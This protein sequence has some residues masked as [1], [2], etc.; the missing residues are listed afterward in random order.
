MA[1]RFEFLPADVLGLS[2]LARAGLSGRLAELGWARS[3]DELEPPAV[4]RDPLAL[5]ERQV[6][7]ARLE[8]SVASLEPPV[9]VLDAVRLLRRP[10]AS[11]V[12]ARRPAGLLASPLATLHAAAAAVRLARSLAQRWERPVVAG[13]W[14]DDTASAAP[15]AWVLGRHH[16]L[17]R[18]SLEALGDAPWPTRVELGT[19][20]RVG[21]LRAAARH[22]FGDYP[23]VDAALELVAPREGETLA[24]AT[25]RML[26]GAFGAH[27][28]VPIDP[29]ALRAE[30]ASSLARLA[31]TDV[32][33]AFERTARELGG[34]AA[35]GEEFGR[36]VV[37]LRVGALAERLRVGGEGYVSD[38]LAGARTR[39]ELAAAAVQEPEHWSPGPALLPACLEAALPVAVH[40]AGGGDDLPASLARRALLAPLGLEAR[41]LVARAPVTLVEPEVRADLDRA[42]VSA[43]AALREGRAE[44]TPPLQPTNGPS[45][46]HAVAEALRRA[47]AKAREKVLEPKAELA[48]I[49][50]GLAS[51]LER[52]G[53]DIG[54]GLEKLARRVEHAEA[55]LR[56]QDRR[57]ARRIAASL[58]PNGGAQEDTLSSFQYLARHGT[59]WLDAL[60]DELE[61]FGAEHVV[62]T[63]KVPQ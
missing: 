35:V 19:A 13:L 49:D 14:I 26:T 31:A 55:N 22:L 25:A 21:A 46:D 24:R 44:S 11:L 5:E 47:A 60:V 62:L 29:S 28:L 51:Q 16:D 23:H 30:L 57:R 33:G 45:S 56:G 20:H 37:A 42:G 15:E 38:G 40:V 50:P 27:G 8:L 6:L 9:A 58:T 12:L 43:E 52:I 4:E 54:G 2:A 36:G 61:P 34:V 3:M 59:G 18:L 32:G 48:R 7:V 17:Q 53:R 10:D 1:A 41:P 39:A 63:L